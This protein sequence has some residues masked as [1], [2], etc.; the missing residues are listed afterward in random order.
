MFDTININNGRDCVKEKG[1][2][3]LFHIF[4]LP[5]YLIDCDS[6]LKY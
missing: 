5:T 3:V 2:S 4:F 1:T 6:V